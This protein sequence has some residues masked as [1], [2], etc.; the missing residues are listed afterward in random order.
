M[1]EDSED[2]PRAGTPSVLPIADAAAYAG[3]SLKALR[4][5][6]DR[7]SIRAVRNDGRILVPVSELH[8]AGLVLA[9]TLRARTVEADSSQGGTEGLVQLLREHADVIRQQAEQLGEYR[10]LSAQ[11]DSLEAALQVEHAAR[12]RLEAE[13]HESRARTTSAE[14][15]LEALRAA[16][17]PRRRWFRS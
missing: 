6:I 2:S 9:G 8:R 14:A 13:L 15:Q 3:L 5:R 4:S 1:T 11:T 7:G 17:P 16:V 10:A 12:E